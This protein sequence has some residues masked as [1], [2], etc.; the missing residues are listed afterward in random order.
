MSHI[1]NKYE[2]TLDTFLETSNILHNILKN[3]GNFK[4]KHIDLL[5]IILSNTNEL[6]L[7]MDRF[8]LMINDDDY[9]LNEKDNHKI[10]DL[11]HQDIV[12]KKIAPL[13]LLVDNYV[14]TESK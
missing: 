4:G 14:R 1:L 6:L 2:N 10:K 5:N 12:F 3:K 8:I 7:N 13:L 9:E 11:K